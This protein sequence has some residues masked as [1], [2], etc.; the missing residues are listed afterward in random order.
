[1][2]LFGRDCA[3]QCTES[4]HLVG[5]YEF[6]LFHP[7][8]GC[9]VSKVNAMGHFIS[10][11]SRPIATRTGTLRD[12]AMRYRKSLK[13]PDTAFDDVKDPFLCMNIFCPEGSYDPNIEPLKNDVIFGDSEGFLEAVDKCLGMLYPPRVSQA[14]HNES[15][16]AAQDITSMEE[17]EESQLTRLDSPNKTASNPGVTMKVRED[18]RVHASSLTSSHASED[19]QHRLDSEVD[20]PD[21]SQLNSG[22]RKLHMYDLEDEDLPSA[23]RAVQQNQ[24][25]PGDCHDAPNQG[26]N[27]WVLAKM[28]API[29]KAAPSSSRLLGHLQFHR[30]T[31]QERK[32]WVIHIV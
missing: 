18:E 22:R 5:D 30:V 9:S 4:H 15:L 28:S 21:P 20:V 7:L 19:L 12:M 17:L 31:Q 27:P 26:L 16:H 11:D 32:Q 1:M 24:D 13:Q 10:I 25:D 14:H 2:Q 3:N 23:S 8:A 29:Q 6:T